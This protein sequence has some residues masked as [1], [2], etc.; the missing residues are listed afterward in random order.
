MGAWIAG[1]ISFTW[2][3]F[4]PIAIYAVIMALIA[5]AVIREHYFSPKQ[6][7]LRKMKKLMDAIHRKNQ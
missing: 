2:W 3:I 7:N 5:L 6:K 4:A 1:G